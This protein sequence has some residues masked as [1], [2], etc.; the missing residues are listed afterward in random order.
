MRPDDPAFDVADG[1]GKA[2][3]AGEGQ[4]FAF[5][6]A[7]NDSGDIEGDGAETGVNALGDGRALVWL[8]APAFVAALLDG[9][10]VELAHG[11]QVLPVFSGEDVF[12]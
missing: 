11:E 2:R 12:V 6:L 4:V 8:G 10:R 3:R 5:L 9:I 1:D 7:D